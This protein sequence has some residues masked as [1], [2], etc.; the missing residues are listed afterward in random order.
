[1]SIY[2]E[3][4]RFFGV[5]GRF[6]GFEVLKKARAFV[7]PVADGTAGR[8]PKVPIV[9]GVLLHSAARFLDS[10][11]LL[12]VIGLVVHAEFGHFARL[13]DEDGAGVADIRAVDSV[14]CYEADIGR[15]AHD[16]GRLLEMFKI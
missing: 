9:D 5:A 16:E 6:L 11:Q 3:Y 15:A 12:R 14:I 8:E 2:G 10:P 7:G 4:A 13:V 1:M